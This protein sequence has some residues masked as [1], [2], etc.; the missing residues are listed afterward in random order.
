LPPVSVTVHVTVVIPIGKGSTASFVTLATAQL[1]AVTGI[2]RTTPDALQI[3]G[4]ATTATEAGA[5]IVG[6]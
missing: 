1:S 2:P 4:S 5:V 6:F 3:P